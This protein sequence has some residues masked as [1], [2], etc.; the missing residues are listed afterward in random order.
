VV[1]LSLISKERTV[2]PDRIEVIDPITLCLGYRH[3][4][5]ASSRSCAEFGEM[6]AETA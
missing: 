4:R 6:L 5:A 2:K 1:H 3:E